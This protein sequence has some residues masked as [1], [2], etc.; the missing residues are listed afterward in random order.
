MALLPIKHMEENLHTK[1]QQVLDE[2]NDEIYTQTIE[3][4]AE[5]YQ[6]LKS[7]HLKVIIHHSLIFN[8]DN[9]TDLQKQKRKLQARKVIGNSG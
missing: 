4:S 7:N 6:S 1:N 9:I 8:K 5:T 3:A 2:K